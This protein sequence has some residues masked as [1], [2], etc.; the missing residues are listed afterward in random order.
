MEAKAHVVGTITDHISGAD[1]KEKYK[2]TTHIK[3]TAQHTSGGTEKF[4]VTVTYSVNG[5][6]TRTK[7][8]NQISLAPGES[9]TM[10]LSA[11]GGRRNWA[12]IISIDVREN[13]PLEV[14]QRPV[15]SPVLMPDTIP[16]GNQMPP[17]PPNLVRPRSEESPN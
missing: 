3:I 15:R 7:I 12:S 2:H 8:S 6:Y 4:T 13:R 5:S 16:P 1:N 10:R 11:P 9:T 14:L 17:T